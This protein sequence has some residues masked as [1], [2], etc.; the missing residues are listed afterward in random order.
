MPAIMKI[1]MDFNIVA[2]NWYLFEVTGYFK[3]LKRYDY[4]AITDEESMKNYNLKPRTHVKIQKFK[5]KPLIFYLMTLSYEL[6]KEL[7]IKEE[8]D[9][10]SLSLEPIIGKSPGRLI[11][12][13]TWLK[14]YDVSLGDLVLVRNEDIL[15]SRVL[16]KI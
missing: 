3:D 8:F 12:P 16:Q 1:F 15:N 10:E 7:K 5:D 14:N 13:E 6:A 11:M 9:A 2:K 4:V